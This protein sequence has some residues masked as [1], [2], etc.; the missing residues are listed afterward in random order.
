[1]T[2]FYMVQRHKMA[3]RF[4][5]DKTLLG[6]ALKSNEVVGY[7][8][9]NKM[10]SEIFDDKFEFACVML[11]RTDGRI[12]S[13]AVL[14]RSRE[15]KSAIRIVSIGCVPTSLPAGISVNKALTDVVVAAV[16]VCASKDFINVLSDHGRPFSDLGFTEHSTTL[17]HYVSWN[18]IHDHIVIP[19][20]EEWAF[21]GTEA[22][23]AV[24]DARGVKKIPRE[25]EHLF[26][27]GEVLN[28]TCGG[29]L[30]ADYVEYLLFESEKNLEC[31]FVIRND[32]NQL[33]GIAVL[34]MIPADAGVPA[35]GELFILCS[36]RYLV[37]EVKG[38]DIMA[39]VLQY[40]KCNHGADYVHLTAAGK[41][42]YANNYPSMGFMGGKVSDII[43]RG[44]DSNVVPLHNAV[45]E[46]GCY[47]MTRCLSD[48]ES[49]TPITL[50]PITR[51]FRSGIN[52]T[53]IRRI[54]DELKKWTRKQDLA[55]H[56]WGGVPD[57]LN[58]TEASAELIAND[59]YVIPMDLAPMD[60]DDVT[61]DMYDDDS[62]DDDNAFA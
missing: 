59:P 46:D 35:Y 7:T 5:S 55:E 16:Q 28:V 51:A 40:F 14:H 34:G 54:K 47:H 21:S 33:T 27:E 20:L 10:R 41:A 23:M 9:G 15:M 45:H 1:M 57:I 25:F 62:S 60:E 48:I 37:S 30:S 3:I 18:W 56:I 42:L 17:L 22:I 19:D 11:N 12:A 13:I 26:A 2:I 44:C 49:T 29:A 43:R 8:D 61:D 4:S 58:M 50:F 36:N 32:T 39:R 24:P 52:N 6:T 31:M 53:E 38:K